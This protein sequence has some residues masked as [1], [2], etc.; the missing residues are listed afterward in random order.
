MTERD[1]NAM[2]GAIFDETTEI[3]IVEL[4]RVCSIEATLVEELIDEGILEPIGGLREE[5]RFSY[6]SIRRTHTVIHLQRDLGLNLAGAALALELLDRIDV[7]KTQ[8]RR[9]R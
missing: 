7:L 8:L 6:S 3:T 9:K 2:P 5:R 4:R 1:T